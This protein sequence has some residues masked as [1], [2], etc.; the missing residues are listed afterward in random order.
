[1]IVGADIMSKDLTLVKERDIIWDGGRLVWR[2]RYR[3]KSVELQKS[4]PEV[5]GTGMTIAFASE[6]APKAGGHSAWSPEEA[7]YR[8]VE[9]GG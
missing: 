2:R 8:A 1:M 4:F 7:V 9:S 5:L 6:E 3:W